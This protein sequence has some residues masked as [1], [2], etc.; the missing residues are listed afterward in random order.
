M[1][2]RDTT[3]ESFSLESVVAVKTHLS[4]ITI[5]GHVY[6]CTYMKRDKYV[7][8]LLRTRALV[9]YCESIDCES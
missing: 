2:S 6:T 4:T 3:P 7:V 5:P 9:Y 1:A 8:L